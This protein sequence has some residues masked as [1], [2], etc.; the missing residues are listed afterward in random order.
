MS[1]INTPT[2]FISLLDGQ[3]IIVKILG[4]N[5]ALGEVLK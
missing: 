4:M 5:N 1:L 2:C 3:K